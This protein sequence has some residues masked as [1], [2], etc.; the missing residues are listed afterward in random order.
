MSP[1][2]SEPSDVELTP[3]EE[4]LLSDTLGSSEF[5]SAVQSEHNNTAME[6]THSHPGAYPHSESSGKTPLLT[7]SQVSRRDSSSRSGQ[8]EPQTASH[9]S[10]SQSPSDS[11]SDDYR[12][13]RDSSG[14]IDFEK[15]SRRLDKDNAEL[16]SPD[17]VNS[18]TKQQKGVKDPD[19]APSTSVQQASTEP[20]YRIP[21]RLFLDLH[22]PPPREAPEE[23]TASTTSSVLPEHSSADVTDSW[24]GSDA[25]TGDF[26]MNMPLDTQAA[27]ALG[28][29]PPEVDTQRN[30]V[31]DAG[32]A[33]DT[34][35]KCKSI[36]C[37]VI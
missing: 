36:P 13:V 16:K 6:A 8:N 18:I 24:H 4:E 11:E 2:E 28:G 35:G 1:F 29:V 12:S 21:R 23:D 30:P 32:N 25:L 15:L 14:Y 10:F 26:V 33:H 7:S 5:H 19:A 31:T 27:A 37:F 20:G 9:H 34:N 17:G 22:R 3:S